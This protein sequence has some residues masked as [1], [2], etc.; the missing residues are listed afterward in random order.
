MHLLKGFLYFLGGVF[1]IALAPSAI[2]AAFA[3]HATVFADHATHQEVLS[4]IQMAPVSVVQ[5]DTLAD[6]NIGTGLQW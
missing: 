4:A 6:F 3:T 1:C 2:A 5:V